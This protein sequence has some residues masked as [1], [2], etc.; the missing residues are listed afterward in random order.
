MQLVGYTRNATVLQM[1]S[2]L[3]DGTNLFAGPVS[4]KH[5]RS[6]ESAV[7]A[8]DHEVHTERRTEWFH[9]LAATATNGSRC[10]AEEESNIASKLRR[11]LAQLTDGKI[12]LP[13]PIQSRQ[14][15]RCIA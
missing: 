9:S 8:G 12:Q 1:F 11:Q 3:V 13:Q 7:W 15:C 5:I 6:R 2:E 10:G 14:C 4:A